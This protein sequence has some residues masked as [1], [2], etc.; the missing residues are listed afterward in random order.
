MNGYLV[1]RSSTDAITSTHTATHPHEQKLTLRT[2]QKRGREERDG[3]GG[4][5]ILASLN[6]RMACYSTRLEHRWLKQPIEN[7][8]PKYEVM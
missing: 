6:D 4:I 3:R 8:T 1:S 7:L 2:E 5:E